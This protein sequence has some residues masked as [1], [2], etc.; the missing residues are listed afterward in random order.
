MCKNIY[1][2][3]VYIHSYRHLQGSDFHNTVWLY[4][5]ICVTRCLNVYSVFGEV[6]REHECQGCVHVG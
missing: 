6:L 2:Y 1:L 5:G 4:S 3:Y